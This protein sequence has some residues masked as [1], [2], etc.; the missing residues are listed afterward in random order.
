M[1]NE[2]SDKRR[3]PRQRSDDDLDRVRDE[4]VSRYTA[5]VQALR[6]LGLS[7]GTPTEEIDARYQSLLGELA[8]S[9]SAE[10]RRAQ[11]RHAYSIL[12]QE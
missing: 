12:K 9:S 2:R 6:L 1:P 7:V 8:N 4:W 5:R 3:R 11:L 10:E